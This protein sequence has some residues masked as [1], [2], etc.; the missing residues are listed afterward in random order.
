MD[1]FCLMELGAAE[2]IE[3]SIRKLGFKP[4][5]IK[6]LLIIHDDSRKY[7]DNGSVRG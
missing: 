6:L 3:E 5:D 7:P 4:E 1:I 2:D